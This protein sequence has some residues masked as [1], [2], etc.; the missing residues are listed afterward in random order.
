M[1]AG[2]QVQGDNVSV[3]LKIFDIL[4][5]E[6]ARLVDQRQKPGNYEVNFNAIQHPSGVYF[7]QLIVDGFIETKKMVLLQ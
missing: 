1:L 4:G 5:H 3:T 2:R 7:Y 6:V